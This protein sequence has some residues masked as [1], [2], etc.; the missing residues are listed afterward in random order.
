M[1]EFVIYCM[2]KMQKGNEKNR[3]FTVYYFML[4]N[5]RESD[6]EKG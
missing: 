2:Q 4:G 6:S 5:F 3:S 1:S